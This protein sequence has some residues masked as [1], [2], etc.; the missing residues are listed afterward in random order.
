M[1]V[2]NAVVSNR[3][4]NSGLSSKFIQYAADNIDHNIPTLDVKNTFNGI[5]MIAAVKPGT[6]A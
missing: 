5:G 3:T 1:C 4:D 6:I 2:R